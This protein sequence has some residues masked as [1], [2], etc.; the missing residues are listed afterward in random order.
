MDFSTRQ[1]DS[2]IEPGDKG[3]S[4]GNDAGTISIVMVTLG[5]ES[6]TA[7]S[8]GTCEDEDSMTF[9]HDSPTLSWLH[10]LSIRPFYCPLISTQDGLHA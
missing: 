4:G 3:Q 2:E 6:H 7:E 10:A 9:C 8:S 5:T 1:V